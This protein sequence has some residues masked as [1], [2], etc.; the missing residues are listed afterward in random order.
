LVCQGKLWSVMKKQRTDNV[1]Y[2]EQGFA[3]R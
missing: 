1:G 2:A 3:V